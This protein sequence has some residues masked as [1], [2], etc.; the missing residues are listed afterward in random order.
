MPLTFIQALITNY[1]VKPLKRS[2]ADI[3]DKLRIHYETSPRMSESEFG[4]VMKFEDLIKYA[5][6]RKDFCPWIYDISADTEI[7][8]DPIFWINENWKVNEFR[9]S[10]ICC[11][12]NLSII[13]LQNHRLIEFFRLAQDISDF[14]KIDI[15]PNS[16]YEH[17]IG[18][19][20]FVFNICFPEKICSCS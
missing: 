18:E 12:S 6:S 7:T 10:T 15:P 4:I 2:Q 3:L 1:C 17:N 11:N 13:V 5:R 14:L 16:S 9:I 19:S 20:N 8:G